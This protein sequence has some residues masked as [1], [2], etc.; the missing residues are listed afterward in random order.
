MPRKQD[1]LVTCQKETHSVSKTEVCAKPCP[2]LIRAVLRTLVKC[3]QIGILILIGGDDLLMADV[4]RTFPSSRVTRS[5]H[6][7][8]I[9]GT[10]AIRS[11][12]FLK[13]PSSGNT[14]EENLVPNPGVQLLDNS[15]SRGIHE[16][17][18]TS[19]SAPT[20][21]PQLALRNVCSWPRADRRSIPCCNHW[22]SPKARS[23][24]APNSKKDQSS[25]L[26]FG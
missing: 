11:G 12:R 6:C 20:E 7:V 15:C 2:K 8:S 17:H 16:T 9:Q 21:W 18:E 5:K 4:R 23:K 22:S 24:R 26:L 14:F 3:V 19:G 25:N 13:F 1:G 10:D